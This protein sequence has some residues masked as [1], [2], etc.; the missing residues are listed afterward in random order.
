MHAELIVDDR[1][2]VVPHL[3]GTDRVVGRLGVL[4]D[5]IQHLIVVLNIDARCNL[6]RHNAL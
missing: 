2:R 3:A 1:H 6:V 5:P 4:L